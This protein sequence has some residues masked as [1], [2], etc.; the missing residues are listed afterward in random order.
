MQKRKQEVEENQKKR[1]KKKSRFGYYLYA[2]TVLFLTVANILVATFLLTYVQE[3]RVE[4]TK[5]SRDTQILEWIKEDPYTINSIYTVA[6]YKMGSYELPSYLESVQ[7]GFEMPWRL[8]V[9]VE[10]K[11]VLGCILIENSYVYFSEDGIVLAMETERQDGIP[12]IEGLEVDNIGLY[13]KLRMKNERVFSYVVNISKEVT[14][15][16]LEPERLVWEDDGMSLYFGEICVRLGKISFDEKLL[17]LPPIL[18]ELEGKS[19]ILHMEH[20][21]EMSDSISFEEN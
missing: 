3:I 7:V 18:E 17:E 21:S 1:R 2:V 5:Y 6:K 11:E 4:G 16:Q 13:E 8:S 14:K 15:N 10:E 20:Y 12:V 19:G 9:K